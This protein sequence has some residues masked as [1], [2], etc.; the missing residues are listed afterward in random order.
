M[1]VIDLAGVVAIVV[2][3]IGNRKTA[4]GGGCGVGDGDGSCRTI[5]AGRVVDRRDGQRRSDICR[6]GRHAA[7]PC[8]AAKNRASV[9]QRQGQGDITIP[10]AT[11]IHVVIDIASTCV[12]QATI[13]I[14][15]T[16]GKVPAVE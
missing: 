16:I 8:V 15:S 7:A 9:G 14:G 4:D 12:E 11:A 5:D 6:V 2:I 13:C 1:D 10:R 3:D